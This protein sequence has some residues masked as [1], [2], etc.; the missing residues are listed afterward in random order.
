[1]KRR[2]MR[3]G[4]KLLM[5]SGEGKRAKFLV[6]ICGRVISRCIFSRG[7]FFARFFFRAV[8]FFSQCFV[9]RGV[10]FFAVFCFS[11]RTRRAKGAKVYCIN[12]WRFFL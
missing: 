4:I 9:S 10:L 11:L 12:V 7:V 1:M 6:N 2:F 3:S 5:L 8:F